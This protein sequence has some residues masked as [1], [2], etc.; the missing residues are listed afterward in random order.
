MPI[1]VRLDPALEARLDQEVRRLG[2][3]KSEFVKDALERVLGLKSPAS[4]LQQVRSGT[5]TG[6]PAC[7]KTSQPK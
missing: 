1:S 2:V 6:V 7:R 5:P 4:L 3:T